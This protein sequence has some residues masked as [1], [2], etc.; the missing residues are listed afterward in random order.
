MFQV[1]GK[2]SG[3]TLTDDSQARK[4]ICEGLVNLIVKNRDFASPPK[5]SQDIEATIE[6]KLSAETLPGILVPGYMSVDIAKKNIS[7]LASFSKNF[8]PCLFN[9]FS[10]ASEDQ[11]PFLQ[12]A[13]EA[14]IS[15]TDTKVLFFFSLFQTLDHIN[16]YCLFV[17][18]CE[19]IFQKCS[20]KA[21]DSYYC[22]N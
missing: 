1:V 20:F 4:D 7:I 17:L 22:C 5:K 19:Y 16:K 15:I 2:N 14:Y 10:T 21:I 11:I 9:V 8:L 3:S 13:I 12:N 6:S 18:A